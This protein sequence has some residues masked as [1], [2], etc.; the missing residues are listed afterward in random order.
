MKPSERILARAREKAANEF[1]GK[2]DIASLHGVTMIG[3]TEEQWVRDRTGWFIG[4][5]IME[6]LDAQEA[7]AD[8]GSK[9]IRYEMDGLLA[10]Y[11]YVKKKFEAARIELIEFID[12]LKPDAIPHAEVEKEADKLIAARMEKTHERTGRP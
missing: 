10:A 12:A 6:W 8:N 4:E 11:E 1:A 2:K 3:V 5:A 7:Q 9:M